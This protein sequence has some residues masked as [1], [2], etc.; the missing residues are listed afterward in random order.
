[1]RRPALAVP[2]VAAVRLALVDQVDRERLQR[3][4]APADFLVDA[5][6]F[7]SSAY[8]PRTKAWAM[9]NRNMSPIPPNSLKFTQ[10][11]VEKL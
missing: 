2:G 8:L 10:R 6:V 9:T 11:S 7:S 3:R 4:K 1:V 5:Q